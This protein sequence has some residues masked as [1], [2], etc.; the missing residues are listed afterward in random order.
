MTVKEDGRIP[1]GILVWSTGLAPNPLIKSVQEM[2]KHEKTQRCA[3][4]L[5]S[6]EVTECCI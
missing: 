5:E 6:G 4:E 3:I 1:F 2:E